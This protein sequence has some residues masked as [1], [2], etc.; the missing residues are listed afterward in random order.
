MTGADDDGLDGLRNLGRA[1]TVAVLLLVMLF[2]TL[3]VAHGLG[4]YQF[5]ACFTGSGAESASVRPEVS[6]FPPRIDCQFEGRDGQTHVRRVPVDRTVT[7]AV[8]GVAAVWLGAAVFLAAAVARRV[9]PGPLLD[10][11]AGTAGTGVL[12]GA[13]L[14]G[15]VASLARRQTAVSPVPRTP[16]WSLYGAG[17]VPGAVLAVIG[18]AAFVAAWRS[19]RH[20]WAA[21]LATAGALSI[22][23]VITAAVHPATPRPV[24]AVTVA[25]T[26]AAL[27]RAG[28]ALRRG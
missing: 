7:L 15:L 5:T 10:R 17:W 9:S 27:A 12:V 8:A 4:E 6:W 11:L 21:A 16:A 3:I 24:P 26:A 14:I 25:L 22:F 23:L 13:V 28:Q 1:M 2:G 19:R 18:L 20:G